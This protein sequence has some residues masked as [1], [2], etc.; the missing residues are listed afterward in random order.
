MQICC[1]LA[2]PFF[3]TLLDS[4]KLVI[5]VTLEEAGPFMEGADGFGVGAV[6]LLAAL[7]A[8]PDEAEVAQHAKMLGDRGL[9][10]AEGNHDIANGAFSCGEIDQDFAPAGFGDRVEGIGSGACS[11]HDETLH[12]YIGICQEIP[13]T[14]GD[15][16]SCA[17]ES[18]VSA[19]YS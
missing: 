3:R 5:P 11:G 8:H 15:R 18:C 13:F 16:R 19:A 14:D 1:A 7:A 17:I 9:F 12:S 4:I 2:E 6:E 10:E